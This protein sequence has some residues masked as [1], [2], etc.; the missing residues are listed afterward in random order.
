MD[1]K[2]IIVF[3]LILTI[4]SLGVFVA[5]NGI[6]IGNYDILPM[7]EA[8][9]LGLDLRG[10]VYVVLEAEDSKED[11]VNDE[12]L[13]RAIATIRQRVDAFGVAEA[14]VSKQGEKRIR[15]SIPDIQD[16]ERAL[17][18]IGKT[19]QLEFIGPDDK[20]ILTGSQVVDSKAVY[21]KNEM[22]VEQPVVTL[23]FNSEGTKAFAEATKKFVN[24][25][26]SIVLDGD[27]ISDPNVL[28]E[29]TEGEAI[30]TGQGSLEEAARLSTLIRAGALPVTLKAI[31]IRTVGPTLGQDSLSKS[32]IAGLIGII[33]V[34]LFMT[35]YYRLPGF[36]SSIALMFYVLIFFAI[37]ISINVTL[38]L[39][40][41]A[42]L[43]LSIGMAVDAN[44]IIF[45]RIKEE[46]NLGKTLRT[47]IDSGFSRA[48][49]S[50]LD[51][52]I[53]TIIAGV[54]LF[55]LGSGPI[56]GFSVTLMIGIGVSMFTAIVV[57]R[58]LLRIVIRANIFSNIKLY[59]AGGK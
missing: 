4:L 56:K 18:L 32:L 51:S 2:Y 27:V 33:L 40:G 46:L 41:I 43:I 9:K 39:P 15:V 1:L 6:S 38:T 3:I 30:I 35:I 42:G 59:G 23:V 12:K 54:V 10:G 25:K 24:Q 34:F 53:T 17:E 48:L 52:N 11:P 49:T 57:T 5:I 13:S 16:Q 58:Y 26:I 20:V 7:K 14:S 45:E 22:G 21:Q 50:I 36:L 37:I 28:H 19:A 31:E 47:S 8:I 29:I 44:V 55:F